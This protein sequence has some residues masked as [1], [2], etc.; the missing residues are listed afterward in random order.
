MLPQQFGL[1]YEFSRSD[2]QG[3]SDSRKF[4][5]MTIAVKKL[6]IEFGL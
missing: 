2:Q 3:T 6:D 5:L 4:D 1:A